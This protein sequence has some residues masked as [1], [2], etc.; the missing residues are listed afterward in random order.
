MPVVGDLRQYVARAVPLLAGIGAAN[1]RLE[2]DHLVLHA[3]GMARRD[4]LLLR[5][6]DSLDDAVFTR[7]RDDLSRRLTREPLQYVLGNTPFCDLDLEVGSGVLIPR[8][9]TEVL[10]QRVLHWVRTER[11]VPV[12]SSPIL[13]DVGTGSGAILLALLAALPDWR[14]IGVDISP[15]A[16]FYARRNRNR[17]EDLASRSHLVCG[18]LLGVFARPLQRSD[19][20]SAAT[21]IH[22]PAQPDVLPPSAGRI[23]LVV[24]NP[25]YID[26][27]D[28]SGLAPEVRSHEPAI[29]LD[30]G[31]DGLDPARK[32]A[33]QALALL[34]TGGLLAFELAPSQPRLLAKELEARGTYRVLECFSD[35]A[36]RPRGIVAQRM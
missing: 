27:A 21:P 22:D 17:Y 19:S 25:P 14:G 12:K 16:L 32:I 36:G 24:S 7:F 35:L 13:V 15:A 6:E 30:G 1:P 28:V 11:V 10:V 4:Y 26:S 23:Q 2:A 20:S 29:A 9:E 18:D 33:T 34:A 8:P 3:L 5:D 31:P